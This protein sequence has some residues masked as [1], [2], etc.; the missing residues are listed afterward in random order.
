MQFLFFA[1]QVIDDFISSQ[2][3]AEVDLDILVGEWQLLWGTQVS[4]NAYSTGL[5]YY[6]F[7][8]I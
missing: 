4:Q 6:L 1:R 2:N 5:S 7:A 8:Y 3:G